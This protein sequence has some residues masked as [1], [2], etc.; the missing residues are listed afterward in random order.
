MELTVREVISGSQMSG[1][2]PGMHS[3]EGKPLLHKLSLILCS[4][5]LSK[6]TDYLLS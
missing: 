4:Y 1:D 3:E 5:S 6:M 2:E